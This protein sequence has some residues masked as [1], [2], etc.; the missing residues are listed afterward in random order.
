M[1]TFFGFKCC[2]SAKRRVCEL[3]MINYSFSAEC[4][5]DCQVLILGSMPGKASLQAVQYYAHKRNAFW[6]IMSSLINADP[7]LNYSAR[8]SR[9]KQ[10]GF[11]LWDVYRQCYREGSLDSAIKVSDAEFNA[12]DGA[13]QGLPKLQ[14][15]AL[16]GQAAAKAF[17]RI[18][19]EQSLSLEKYNIQTLVLP[20]TSPAYA[21]MDFDEKLKQWSVLSQYVEN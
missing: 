17:Q 3:R 21:A 7:S 6:P 19:K 1:A 9:L 20:S 14:C 4:N 5:S 16:N 15:I 2:L 12:I 8:L 11:G 10:A 13:I 18:E